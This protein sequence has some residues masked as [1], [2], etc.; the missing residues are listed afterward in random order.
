M[1]VIGWGEKLLSHFS[2]V[3]LWPLYHS[4]HNGRDR[5]VKVRHEI[6]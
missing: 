1:G 5:S 3:I 2:G 4:R 6:N